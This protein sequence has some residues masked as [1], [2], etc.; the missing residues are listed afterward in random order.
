MN[1]RIKKKWSR[2]ER[3]E[4]KVAQLTAENILLTDALRNHADNIRDLDD[5][6]KRNA[7]ATNSRFDKLEKQVANGNTKKPFWKR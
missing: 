7:Q 5:I 2:I 4:N 6:V 3:L 1:K